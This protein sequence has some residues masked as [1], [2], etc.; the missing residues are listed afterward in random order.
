MRF[1]ILMLAGVLAASQ[2]KAGQDA[3]I[4]DGTLFPLP[5]FSL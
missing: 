2:K 4:Y 1:V 5:H 3:I